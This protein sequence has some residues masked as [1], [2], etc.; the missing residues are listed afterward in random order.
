M[1][2]ITEQTKINKWDSLFEWICRIVGWFIIIAALYIY[3]MDKEFSYR[4]IT[5][6]VMY[7]F[8]WHV[9]GLSK[10]HKDL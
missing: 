3:Y 1:E 6:I 8:G 4:I 2:N 10:N 5:L 7:L 9:I